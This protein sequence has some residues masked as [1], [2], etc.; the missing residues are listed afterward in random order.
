MY[1]VHVFSVQKC[2][3]KDIVIAKLL[4]CFGLR[5]FGCAS[6]VGTVSLCLYLLKCWGEGRCHAQLSYFSGSSSGKCM[7]IRFRNFRGGRGK[8]RQQQFIHLSQ[9]LYE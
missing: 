9:V 3:V 6:A 7:I 4:L 1:M 8:G 5:V 2:T